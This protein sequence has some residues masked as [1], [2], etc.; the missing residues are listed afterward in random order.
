MDDDSA[1]GT[2]EVVR[3][4]AKDESRL[5]LIGR[6][7][8]G[9]LASAINE[10]LLNSTGDL[11]VVMNS[12][13]QH[14]PSSVLGAIHAFLGGEYDLVIGSRF[15]PDARIQGLSSRREAGSTWAKRAARS[16][17]PSRYSQLTDYMS[18]FFVLHVEPLFPLIRAVDVNGFKF[19]YELLA[20]SKGKLRTAEIPIT[21]Q[22]RSSSSSK[23]DLT[24]FW[25]FLILILHG[26][27]FCMV[28]R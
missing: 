27:S 18:G 11:A 4:L 3:C 7:G 19:L 17:L 14:D 9:G 1:D 22:P 2:A 28:P 8:R 12:D 20:V 10:G 25:D 21:F 16:S 6:I 5:R 23:L 26:F 24:V 13:G 15:H